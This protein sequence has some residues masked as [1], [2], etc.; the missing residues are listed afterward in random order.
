MDALDVISTPP[1]L[2]TKPLVKKDS[3][4][5]AIEWALMCAQ[6]VAD[7]WPSLTM[8]TLGNMTKT[9][10]ALREALQSLKK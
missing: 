1:K 4:E 7:R 10:D 5:E 9:I 3:Q 2:V 8:R 6:E